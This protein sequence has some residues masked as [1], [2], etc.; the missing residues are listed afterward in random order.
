MVKKIL[1]AKLRDY[2]C[3]TYVKLHGYRTPLTVRDQAGRKIPWLVTV[4]NDAGTYRF[5]SANVN[6]DGV[7]CVR[8]ISPIGHGGN[9]EMRIF[10]DYFGKKIHACARIENESHGSVSEAENQ[11]E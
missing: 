11:I 2:S 4:D 5:T 10:L 9:F 3:R 7:G 8:Q 6:R 1:I